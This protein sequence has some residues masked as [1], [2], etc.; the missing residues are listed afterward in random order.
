MDS[1]IHLV[2]WELKQLKKSVFSIVANIEESERI[3][4]YKQNYTFIHL[5]F[6]EY[7]AASYL[8]DLLLESKKSVQ[9]QILEYLAAHRNENK[10]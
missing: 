6:M 7:L 1:F 3:D 9:N 8:V 10:F 2:Y 4:M 5:T